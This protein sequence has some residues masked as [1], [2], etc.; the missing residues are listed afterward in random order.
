MKIVIATP[1]YPPEIGG[2]AVYAKELN[3]RFAASGI[4]I[5][6]VKFSDM[7][8]YPKFLRHAVYFWRVFRAAQGADAILAFDTWSTGMPA[9]LVA[10][11]R[12]QKMIVRIGGDFLWETYIERTHMLVKLSEFYKIK[13]N[14]SYK[15]HLIYFGT[16]GIIRCADALVFNTAWQKDLWERAYGFN[17]QKA[18]VIENEYPAQREMSPARG[19]VF[20]AAGRSHSLKN[21]GVLKTA[22]AYL[23]N[24]YPD[25]ELDTRSLPPD[26][27]KARIRSAYAV[28]IPSV[29]EVSP[30]AA[31][32]AIRFGK[33]FIMSSDTGVRER[34]AD[35][36]IFVDTLDM[37]ELRI[38]MESLL[39]IREYARVQVRVQAFAFAHSWEEVTK[40]FLLLIRTLCAS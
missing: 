19:R 16:H 14:F 8:R 23:Q 20:I 6:L 37:E 9:I 11:V 40:E 28:I 30:N 18:S 15:E 24:T 13:R 38:A 29:S 12:R 5:M 2:P 26:E 36:G 22:F 33:P 1:L 35:A 7:R 3:E 25:I 17:P 34:L 10:K 32:D 4:N 39:D 31:I 27:H 21:M